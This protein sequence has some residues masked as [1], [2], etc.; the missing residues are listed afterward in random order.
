MKGSVDAQSFELLRESCEGE[1]GE[2][3][4]QLALQNAAQNTGS[5][6]VGFW[7][8]GQLS[9]IV[10]IGATPDENY[11]RSTKNVLLVILV[12]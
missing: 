1:R 4:V 5:L 6:H 2:H 9:A 8:Y 10:A 3:L 7:E 11:Q 12:M